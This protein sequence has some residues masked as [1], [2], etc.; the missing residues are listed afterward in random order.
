MTEL[1]KSEYEK[2][3]RQLTGF[4]KGQMARDIRV[5]VSI[6]LQRLTDIVN[7]QISGQQGTFKTNTC[8]AYDENLQLVAWGYPALA[9]EPPK[10]IKST[11]RPQPKPVELFKLHLANIKE[12]EKPPLP[13]G[14][15]SKR[16]VTDYL[17]EMNKVRFVCS[18]PAEWHH[19]AKAIMRE[20]MYNAGYLDHRLSENLEFTTEPEAAAIYCMKSLNEYRLTPGSSF[21][22][23]DCGGGTVD[24]TTRTL[25]PAMKLSEIT[26]RSGDLCGS[27]YVD[28]EFLK[29]LGKKLGYAA[30][31]KL[32]ENN[33]GQ[34]QY[35]VQQFC[36]RVKFAFNG[37]PTEFSVKEL[38]IER[39]CPALVQYVEGH[40]KEQMEEADWLVEFDFQSVKDMFDPVVN[41]IIELIQRQLSSTERK[42]AAMFLVGGFSESLYLQSQIRRHFATQVPIIA[43][44]RHPIA[45]IVRGALEYG[46]HMEVIQTRVLKFCYGVEVSAK[47]DKTDPFERRTESGR[48]FRFH[49]LALRGT[50]V[51]V[52]QKFCYTAGP[53]VPNQTDMTFNIF[54]T[55][56]NNARY[57]DEEG[58]R[59]L[60]KMKIDLP[61]PHRGKNR[62]VE[63]TL[64]FGT[65][66]IKAT[67]VNKRTGQVYESSFILE[68]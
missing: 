49:K 56:N 37:N 1:I 52:D 5:V 23:V 32:K 31:R 45:A 27:S 50:E 7:V 44:P 63:F 20:C 64:T 33:Y 43:V 26:E 39:V 21:M 42:C 10:R 9:Q 2:W 29:F 14:L 60:G 67:A 35:L 16:A 46:L 54:T 17:H 15:D 22:I 58:M 59:M 13:P 62:L 55:Q 34:M 3:K 48:V 47:W 24:L 53:V 28:R 61:D 8:L 65:M 19:E 66:E 40:A 11:A 4:L 30:M 41:K 12:D 25:L 51:A 38:D 18:V 68:F 57:C 36:S 6:E